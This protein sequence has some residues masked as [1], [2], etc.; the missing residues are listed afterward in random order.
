LQ[1]ETDK[2]RRLSTA[3]PLT[4]TYNRFGI[5]QIVSTLMIFYK[6]KDEHQNSP[7]FALTR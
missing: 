5:D 3:D 7:D 1:R 2:F 6:E 4:Q